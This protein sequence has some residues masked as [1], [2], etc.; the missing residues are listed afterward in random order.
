MCD[1]ENM[2]CPCLLL[3]TGWSAA[4]LYNPVVRSEFDSFR[5]RPDTFSLGVCNGCQLMGLLGW[6]A[7]DGDSQTQGDRGESTK[8][9]MRILKT[10]LIMFPIT[11]SC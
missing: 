8:D 4:I 9:P 3:Y 2:L 1:I 11:V 5:A 10:L 7:P 6:V